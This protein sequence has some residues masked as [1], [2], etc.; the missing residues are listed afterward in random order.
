MCVCYCWFAFLIFRS[1]LYIA[2]SIADH[3]PHRDS[4]HAPNM[5][6]SKRIVKLS[7]IIYWLGSPTDISLVNP[8]LAAAPTFVGKPPC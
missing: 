6:E 3:H 7:S 8:Y 4:L 5:T 2:S 1:F